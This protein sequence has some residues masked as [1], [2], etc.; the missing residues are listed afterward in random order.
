MQAAIHLALLLLVPLAL[1]A[2]CLRI[3]GHRL[4]DDRLGWCAW[5]YVAGSIATA[6][7]LAAWLHFGLPLRAAAIVPALAAFATLLGLWPVE[8]DDEEPRRKPARVAVTA[9]RAAFAVAVAVM[10]VSTV[11][12]LA[13]ADA[14]AV[15]WGDEAHMWSA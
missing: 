4:R 1:G 12:R 14:S 15:T 9:E 2:A 3:V 7:V 6:A 5:A 11:D 13:L 10:L 8:R